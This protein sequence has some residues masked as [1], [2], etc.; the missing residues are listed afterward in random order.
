MEPSV[1]I[2][3]QTPDSQQRGIDRLL[4]VMARLR[5]PNG[6][7]PWDLAQS[8]ATIVPHTIEEA[9][10]VAEAIEHRD[11]GPGG[12]AH[13]KDE[14]GDLLFQVVFYAQLAGEEQRFDFDAIADS[15]ANKMIER[16]PHVFG[17]KVNGTGEDDSSLWESRKADERARRAA[18]EGKGRPSVLDGI[19]S[20]LPAATRALKLQKRAA[21]VGFDWPEAA[22]VI[23]KLDEEVAEIKAVLDTPDLS[24]EDKTD[25]LEDEI[26][27]A[28]FAL[29]N[30]ARHLK[31]DP[32]AAL[33]RTNRKFDRR[34]R[35]VEQ[36]VEITGRTLQDA[37]LDEMEAHWQQAKQTD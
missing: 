25:A 24:P 10:E 16:H 18:A 26:G 36:A 6:G 2:P 30:L 32:E 8:F 12:D 15:H 4:A 31:I 9:Y 20:G 21:R 5:D 3:Q 7:C 29:V 23:H 22:Q 19:T 1:R 34:F 33:R 27:D 13:L 14:L 17:P 37:N 35:H 11:A 28:L